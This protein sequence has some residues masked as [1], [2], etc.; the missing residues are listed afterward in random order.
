MVKKILGMFLALL[1]VTVVGVGAYAATIYFQSTGM[2]S[3]TYK[4]FGNETDVISATK[5]MTVLFLGVDTGA[6]SR[7]D[8]WEGNSDTMLLVTVNPVTKKTTMMSLER[9]ILTE[10]DRDGETVQAKLNAAYANGG[11]KLAISTIEKLMNIHIDRYVMINMEGLVQLVNAVGGVTV[12]NTLGFPISIEEQE[13]EYTSVIEPG[14]QELNGDQALVYAR[15]RYQDPEGDYGRQKRQREVIQKVIAKVLSL[16][17]VSHYQ[18]ILRAVSDNMQTNI[19]I[20]PTTIPQLLG[21]QDALKKIESQ[22]LRGE[23]AT[24][25]DGGSYQIVTSE[26]LLE[27]Q[28]VLRKSLGLDTLTKLE[29]NAVLYESLYGAG[30]APSSSDVDSYGNVGSSRTSTTVETPSYSVPDTTYSSVQEP[31]SYS[32]VE[33]NSAVTPSVVESDTQATTAAVVQ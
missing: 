6:G 5:P 16:N 32:S 15:M 4:G 31:S 11:A 23:D 22:Q 3:R 27:M 33:V 8:K 21:Y 14:V 28:N 1:T 18:A 17:S 26:H 19:E 30:S 7:S 25:A 9:D 20:S 24:L 13:P 2:L 10:I 12:N 29:T